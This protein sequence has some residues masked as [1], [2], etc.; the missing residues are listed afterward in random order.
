MAV[1]LT[2]AGKS[3]G[4]V[5]ADAPITLQLLPSPSKQRKIPSLS[6]L[7]SLDTE[8]DTRLLSIYCYYILLLLVGS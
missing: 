2:P 1:L 8:F 6:R 4:S 3:H 7:R 5:S